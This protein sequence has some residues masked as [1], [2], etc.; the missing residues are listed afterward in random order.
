[1]LCTHADIL[2]NVAPDAACSTLFPHCPFTASARPAREIPVLYMHGRSDVI[3]AGCQTAQRDAVVSGWSMTLD[4]TVSMDGSHTWSR[5]RSASGNV[6]EHIAHDYRAQSTLLGGHCFPG[7]PD[8]GGG[9]FGTR[10]FGCDDTVAFDWGEAVIAFFEA[11][12]RR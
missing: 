2:A 7:S 6:F 1:M 8:I 11:H 9:A 3:V 4:S 10:N 12:P 5:Y